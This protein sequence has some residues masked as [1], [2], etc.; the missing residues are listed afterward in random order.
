MKE[1]TVTFSGI[2]AKP[3]TAEDIKHAVDMLGKIDP[4]NDVFSLS[5]NCE[6]KELLKAFNAFEITKDSENYHSILFGMPVYKKSYVPKGEVWTVNREGKVL[7]KFK[8]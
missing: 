2:Q 8:I 1:E 3:L 6:K 4:I 7:N 5:H